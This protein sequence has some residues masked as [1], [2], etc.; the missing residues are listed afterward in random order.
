MVMYRTAV[1]GAPYSFVYY[2]LLYNPPKIYIR[3]E[4][5]MMLHNQEGGCSSARSSSCC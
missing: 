1:D 4:K 3:F 5:E 2:D